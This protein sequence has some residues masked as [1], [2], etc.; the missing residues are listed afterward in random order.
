MNSLSPDWEQLTPVTQDS[1]LDT[2]RFNQTY[3]YPSRPVVIKDLGDDWSI[4]G[5]WSLSFLAE[6]FGDL[7]F[8]GEKPHPENPLTRE[9]SLAE[10]IAYTASCTDEEPYYLNN[11]NFHNYTALK[12]DYTLPEYFDCWYHAIPMEKRKFNLSWIYIGAA[13]TRSE[14]HL[15]IWNT[16]AWNYLVSGHKLWLFYDKSQYP[17]L[18]EGKVDP[19]TA[20]SGE[21]PLLQQ[22]TPLYC[23]Q[24]PGDTVFTPSTWWHTVLNLDTT[25]SL[26]E[27]FINK[28]NYQEVLAYFK[29]GGNEKA[30]QSM[31]K[32][33]DGHLENTT[34]IN[35]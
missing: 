10:Y 34:A 32:L 20:D 35:H 1:D 19:F 21:Y 28:T 26:T 16:S 15:D 4:P 29:N 33:V 8:Q 5:K 30:W 31:K 9:F 22:A 23:V 11:V 7:K 6:N 2:E 27:N 17:F 18:Y 24:K 14:L 25:F 12:E 3:G 13:K